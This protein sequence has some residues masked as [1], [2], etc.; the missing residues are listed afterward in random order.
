MWW[1]DIF[2][3]DDDRWID[4]YTDVIHVDDYNKEEINSYSTITEISNIQSSH[5]NQVIINASTVSHNMPTF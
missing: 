2:T 1:D 5:N 4:E 3:D